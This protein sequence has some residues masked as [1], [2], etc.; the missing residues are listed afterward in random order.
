MIVA[1]FVPPGVT[2]AADDFKDLTPIAVT[3]IAWLPDGRLAVTFASDLATDVR[4]AV[5]RRMLA[6]SATE[7]QLLGSLAGT[8]WPTTT[9]QQIAYL[10]ARVDALAR[11][12][13][14]DID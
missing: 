12:V 13:A 14:G 5:R 10:K 9:A 11:I 4:A 3:K 6:T 1:A 7:E 8:P 2:V